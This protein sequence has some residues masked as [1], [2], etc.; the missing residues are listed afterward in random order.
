[1]FKK[2]YESAFAV[3]SYDTMP[4]AENIR[5]NLFKTLTSRHLHRFF[6]VFAEQ[7]HL[8]FYTLYSP[9]DSSPDNIAADKHRVCAK[10]EHFKD[11]FTVNNISL[12]PTKLRIIELNNH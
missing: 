8:K 7:F 6:E 9:S 11:I 12:S 3:G 1:M 10:R 5:R 2:K 4:S